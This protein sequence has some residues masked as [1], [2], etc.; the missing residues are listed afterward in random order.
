M[1]EVIINAAGLGSAAIQA[2]LASRGDTDAGSLP[3]WA[4]APTVKDT[5]PVG[6]IGKGKCLGEFVVLCSAAAHS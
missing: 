6:C 1:E 2:P 3:T 4:G 5:Q